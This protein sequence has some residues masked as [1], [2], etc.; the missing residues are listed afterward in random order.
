MENRLPINQT[1]T[2][3]ERHTPDL[4]ITREIRRNSGRRGYRPKQAHDLAAA[5][6][7]SSRRRHRITPAQWQN[8]ERLIQLDWSPQQIAERARLEGS[9]QISHEWIYAYI[10][11]DKRLGGELHRHLRCQKRRRKC[12]GSGRQRRGQ[13]IN[14][15][16]IEHRPAAV[17]ERA[18]VGHW[19]VDTIIGRGPQAA[20]LT[21]GERVSRDTR[22]ATL[23]PR[24]AQATADQLR[25]RLEPLISMVRTITSDNG[26]EFNDHSKI[27]SS[28]GCDFYFA[29]L[30]ASWQRGTN[31]NTN[32]LIR[33]Y[34][35]RDREL[36]TLT[37]P[38]V[39]M[40]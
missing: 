24:T 35:P 38:E 29:D 4:T 27:S 37:G 8:V 31:E 11:A 16:G 34:L 5:R 6:A 19:E 10:Y 39:R 9:L 25:K 28:L 15:V 12:Y 21:A 23:S 2:P 1:G 3:L 22:L 30:Y 40:I 26:K 20:C 13:I 17:G 36:K 33:Q 18:E 14:R 7:H 32:G